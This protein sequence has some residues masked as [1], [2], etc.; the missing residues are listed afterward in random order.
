ML[1]AEVSAAS[2]QQTAD[3]AALGMEIPTAP[4]ELDGVTLFRLRGVSAFPARQ[5]A[6]AR[7]QLV[8][9]AAR[10]PKVDPN[11]L[12]I[13]ETASGLEIRAGKR[14]IGLVLEADARLEGLTR[15][16]LN[17]YCGDARQMMPLYTALHRNIQDVF[18]EHGVQIMTPSYVAD[19]PDAKVVPKERWHTP[20]AAS[21]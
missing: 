5:R 19:P 2:A 8:L 20:P 10:D 17:A 7:A 6:A 3:P 11:E 13:V 15:H 12:E 9:D 1:L 14:S 16:E 18:N 4:V 21:K